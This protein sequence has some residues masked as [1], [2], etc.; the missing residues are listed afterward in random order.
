MLGAVGDQFRARVLGQKRVRHL[1]PAAHRKA[2]ADQ[3]V[4]VLWH[5]VRS[6]S[7]F[8]LSLRRFACRTHRTAW[9]AVEKARNSLVETVPFVVFCG[10]IHFFRARQV[11]AKCEII[12]ISDS[13]CAPLN[14]A[15]SL[16]S[17]SGAA[18]IAPPRV[19]APRFLPFFFAFF[20][21]QRL[22]RCPLSK[23]DFRS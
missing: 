11:A 21:L 13:C 14:H 6:R 8:I 5:Q 22:L 18:E 2:S 23:V 3:V 15:L 19:T 17:K 20:S 12:E 1:H 10:D 16:G 4:D 7:F 9:L